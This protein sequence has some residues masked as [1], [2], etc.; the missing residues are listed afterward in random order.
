MY[1]RQEATVV[2]RGPAWG[3]GKIVRDVFPLLLNRFE[4]LKLGEVVLF[5]GYGAVVG[6]EAEEE[7]GWGEDE[8]DSEDGDADVLA[9]KT[10]SIF[11]RRAFGLVEIWHVTDT[12][13]I[14]SEFFTSPEHGILPPE[15][16]KTDTEQWNWR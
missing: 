12:R 9:G 8:E 6:Q 1:E 7:D 3:I 4:A 5:E 16:G 2:C 13:S 14:R 11:T 15:E 10:R